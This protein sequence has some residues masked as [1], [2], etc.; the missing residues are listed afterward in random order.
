[1]GHKHKHRNLQAA[2]QLPPQQR[3]AH[4]TQVAASFSFTGPL[5]PPDVLAKYNDALP[6]AAERIVSMAERQSAHRQDI[7]KIVVSSNA[8]A[9]KVGPYLGFVVAMTAVGGGIYLMAHGD[10]VYGLA[11]VIGAL[12]SLAGVFIYGKTKQKQDLDDKAQGFLQAPQ[13]K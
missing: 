12:A 11:S 5:P 9:Q 2:Q 3:S 13:R 4:I 7:E 8:H 10:D 1:M 6:G